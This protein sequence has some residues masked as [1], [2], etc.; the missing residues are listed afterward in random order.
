MTVGQSLRKNVAFLLAGLGSGI[1]ALILM[2]RSGGEPLFQP[3]SDFGI[4]IGAVLVAVYTVYRDLRDSN[5]KP[6]S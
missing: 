2:R 4:L 5:G 6:H 1:V 3:Q